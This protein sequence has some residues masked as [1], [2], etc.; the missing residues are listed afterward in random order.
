MSSRSFRKSARTWIR[1]LAKRW[2]EIEIDLKPLSITQ[3]SQSRW[4]SQSWRLSFASRCNCFISS[5][6]F[7][8]AFRDRNRFWPPPPAAAWF[9]LTFW[10][11]GW[12]SSA[13]IASK[14]CGRHWLNVFKRRS[15]NLLWTKSSR[16]TSTNSFLRWSSLASKW[17]PPV[18]STSTCQLSQA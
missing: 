7:D 8:T 4:F 3:L 14:T 18:S 16:R 15:A 10:S 2:N 17:K 11:C 13:A 12:F 1:I 5:T 6:T 9:S